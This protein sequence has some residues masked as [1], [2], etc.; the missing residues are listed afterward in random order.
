M[1]VPLSIDC[2][3]CILSILE[4]AH[5]DVSSSHADL[6]FLVFL[7]RF[8]DLHLSAWNGRSN[9]QV[10]LHLQE[11]ELVAVGCAL[12]SSAFSH[13]VSVF[14]IDVQGEEVLANYWVKRSRAEYE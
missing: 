12:W 14:E 10:I 8:E 6:S 9:F 11:I 4:V 5:A 3:C 13:A 1:Q 7:V 2:L